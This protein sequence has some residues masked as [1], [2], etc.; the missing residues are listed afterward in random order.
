MVDVVENHRPFLGGYPAREAAAH[1]N[2]DALFHFLL[3]PERSARD[4]LVRVLVEQEDRA[5]VDLEDQTRAVEQRGQQLIETQVRKRRIGDGLQPPDMLRRTLQPHRAALSAKAEKLS[6]RA[7]SAAR[8]TPGE[9][10]RG[11]RDA[12]GDLDENDEV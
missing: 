9:H 8:V 10:R 1:R 11:E 12:G 3:D 6:A 7:L 4:E 2:A 5:G